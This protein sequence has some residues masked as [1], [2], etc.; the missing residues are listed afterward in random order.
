VKHPVEN[1]QVLV[2]YY[3]NINTN[4]LFCENVAFSCGYVDL[5]KFTDG[6]TDVLGTWC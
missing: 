1:S 4:K 6:A 3:D 2:I 5:T